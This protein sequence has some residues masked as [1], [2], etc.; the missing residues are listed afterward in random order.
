L[1]ASKVTIKVGSNEVV[2]DSAGV[3]ITATKITLGGP[4]EISGIQAGSTPGFC[5]LPVCA[6]TGAP[7]TI[8]IVGSWYA[9]FQWFSW[10]YYL[11]NILERR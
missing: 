4:T 9:Q 10:S 3:T 11:I 8:N 1:K 2:I 5:S 7:H 6:F